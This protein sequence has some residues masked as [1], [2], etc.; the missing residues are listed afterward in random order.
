MQKDFCPTQLPSV[1]DG[2]DALGS[3]AP[4]EP[5]HKYCEIMKSLFYVANTT[6]PYI[7]HEVG[8]LSR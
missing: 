5:G 3:G 8:V 1:E 2:K 6:R 4:P 7:A